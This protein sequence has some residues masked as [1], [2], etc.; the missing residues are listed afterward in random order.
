MFSSTRTNIFCKLNNVVLRDFR[1]KCE[2]GNQVRLNN[3]KN[4][5]SKITKRQYYKVP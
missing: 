3:E 1:K 4:V 2:K 5:S